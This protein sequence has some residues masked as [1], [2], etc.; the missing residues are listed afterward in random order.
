M[1]KPSELVLF[2]SSGCNLN[3]KHCSYLCKSSPEQN[4]LLSKLKETID[5]AISLGI[6]LVV[7][8]GREPLLEFPRTKEILEFLKDKDVKVGMVTN[9]TLVA[10]HIEELKKYKFYYLDVSLDGP[11]IEHEINRGE[12]TFEKT[13]DGIKLLLNN[14]NYK[15][16]FLSSTLMSYNYN[17]LP[18]MVKEFS[19][20][21]VENFCFGTYIT[22]KYNPQEWKLE[23]NQML[24]FIKSLKQLEVKGQLIIDIHSEVQ[25]LWEFLIKE[26]VIL[27]KEI[28]FDVN[29]N[30]YYG[31]PETNIYIKS[32]KHTTGPE[33]TVTITAEGYYLPNYKLIASRQYKEKSI[34]NIQNLSYGDYL[35]K[36]KKI[37]NSK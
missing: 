12:G 2:P 36:L 35:K 7:L 11:K 19:S 27:E 5:E 33:H 32:S 18:E 30:C 34:G 9:G 37:K 22:T 26:K 23:E 25:H 31:I 4:V 15:R 29:H 17:A 10:K 14:C 13:R 1:K 20:Y 28:K 16:F 24:D 8:V 21:G 6:K 3:C